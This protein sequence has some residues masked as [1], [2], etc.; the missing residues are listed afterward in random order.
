MIK[1]IAC[2]LVAVFAL[3]PVF[4][5]TYSTKFGK[6]SDEELSMSVYPADSTASAVVL[7]DIGSSTMFYNVTMGK[8]QLKI[9]RHTRVKVFT[10]DGLDWGNIEIAL[11]QDGS[12]KENI[13]DVK[14]VTFNLVND[15]IEKQ[16]LS[17]KDIYYETVSDR[18]RVCKFAMPLVKEGTVFEYEYE[19][20]SDFVYNFQ[21]WDFQSSIPVIYSEYNVLYPDYFTYHHHLSGYENIEVTNNSSMQKIVFSG[22]ERSSTGYVS[23][24]QSYSE[25]VSYTQLEKTFRGSNIPALKS[26]VYIDNITNYISRVSFEL[27][28]THFPREMV[29]SY[30]S[31]WAK[32]VDDFT[33]H[34]DFG[35]QLRGGSFMDEELNSYLSTITESKLRLAATFNFVR[36][37]IKWN[38]KYRVLTDEGVRNAYKNGIG[39][40]ADVNLNLILA[41]EKAGFDVR[42]VI[43]STRS[44]GL[45]LDWKKTKTDFNH[46]IALV[47]LDGSLIVLDATSKIGGIGTI[48]IECLN[49][50]GLIVDAKRGG[51]H[52]LKPELISKNVNYLELKV[53]EDTLSGIVNSLYNNYYALLYQDNHSNLEETNI[54][55]TLATK[56]GNANIDSLKLNVISDSNPEVKLEFNF[57]LVGAV[58]ATGN[59]M[60]ISPFI[61]VGLSTNPF[62]EEERKFPVNFG[63]PFEDSF[64]IKLKIPDGYQV[65]TLPQ[66]IN[67]ILPEGKGR[68]VLSANAVGAD[69]VLVGKMLLN[70]DV[71]YSGD[72]KLLKQFFEQIVSKSNE[73]IVLKK[74]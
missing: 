29:K 11:F 64:V 70:R 37:K 33:I 19:I 52:N 45:I 66:A 58:A 74:V 63:F 18:K 56:F 41:L 4:S 61:G 6:I 39:S 20:V 13:S 10:K 26:E 9:K 23:Q 67:M 16:K 31:T 40:S 57:D 51:W 48:P 43:L 55:K 3:A 53:K 5:Q 28:Q 36:N 49:G 8:F 65:E 12:A 72:Y 24:S 27:A 68:Y 42:P 32:I 2:L 34:S 35:R 7:H 46:V 25:A 54:E 60:Y 21:P 47:E 73:K 59:M 14:G 38:G 15:K 44:N 71:F 69:I 1:K 30:T 50:Q 62:K 17:R 22:F